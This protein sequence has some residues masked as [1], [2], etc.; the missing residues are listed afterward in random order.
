MPQASDELREI[1]F[2]MFGNRI[3]DGGPQLYLL[4]RGWKLTRG[5]RW[6]KRGQTLQSMPQDEY[7][8]VCFL[9]DEWDYGGVIDDKIITLA[10]EPQMDLFGAL[11]PVYRIDY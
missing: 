10:E 11:Y 5:W 3:D 9:I 8:C 4:E 7:L 2:E 1:M 6:F